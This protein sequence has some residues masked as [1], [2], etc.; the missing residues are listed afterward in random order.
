M[1]SVGLAMWK[2]FVMCLIFLNKKWIF[3]L[4]IVKLTPLFA[5][6]RKYKMKGRNENL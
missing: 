5:I 2:L 6:L 4:I 3:M 1:L